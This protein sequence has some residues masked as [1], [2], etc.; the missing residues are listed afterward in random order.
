MHLYMHVFLQWTTVRHVQLELS[1]L[2]VLLIMRHKL[3]GLSYLHSYS[4][5]QQRQLQRLRRYG[6]RNS[7][8]RMHL[9]M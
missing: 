5:F 9:Y 2:S 6:E 3:P 8:L 7:G 1:G 4:L